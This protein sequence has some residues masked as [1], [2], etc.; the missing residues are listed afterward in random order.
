MPIYEV[1]DRSGAGWRGAVLLDEHGDPWLVWAERHNRFHRD[2]SKI[3]IAALM[4]T[5]AEYKIRDREESARETSNWK[6]AVLKEFVEALRESVRTGEAAIASIAGTSPGT[7]ATLEVEVDH[8]EPSDDVAEAHDGLSMLTVSLRI[9]GGGGWGDFEGAL[10]SVCLPFLEPDATQVET[11]YGR[12]NSLIVY[13][14]I[15]HAQLI[16]LLADPPPYDADEPI[17]VKPPDRLHYVGVDYLLDGYVHGKPLRGVCGV[18]F[19]ASRNEA[20]G[21]PVCERCEAEQ[22]AAQMVLDLLRSKQ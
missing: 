21:L 9:S 4:P 19:I 13:V 14:N 1:R 15:T 20:C 3:T 7:T 6:R 10:T 11:A 12:D 2:V 18:W 5:P 16:Q 22:P 17:K 8:D